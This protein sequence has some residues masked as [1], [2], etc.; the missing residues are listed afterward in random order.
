M[1]MSKEEQACGFDV[2]LKHNVQH[3]WEEIFLSLDFESFRACLSVSKAWNEI[4]DRRS[5]RAKIVATYSSQ[6]WMRDVNKLWRSGKYMSVWN[7]HFTR[8][9]M[10]SEELERRR[11][12]SKRYVSAWTCNG[13]GAILK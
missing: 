12:S 8:M 1:K 13:K 6:M 4:F 5:F 11:W 7:A 2:L 3:L 9:W 10:D